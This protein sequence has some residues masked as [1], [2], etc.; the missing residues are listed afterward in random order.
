MSISIIKIIIAAVLAA[1]CI[2]VIAIDTANRDWAGPVLA[3]L[4]GYVVGNA[5]LTDNEPI[6]SRG[7]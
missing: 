5:K 7:E 3:L 2:V 1:A 6:V 4:V